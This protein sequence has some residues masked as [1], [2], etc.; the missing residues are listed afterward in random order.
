MTQVVKSELTRYDELEK[1]YT[2]KPSIEYLLDGVTPEQIRTI[3]ERAPNQITTYISD[4]I[5]QSITV[6]IP[7][8]KAMKLTKKGSRFEIETRKKTYSV[9]EPK[10]L[11]DYAQDIPASILDRIH[12]FETAEVVK[13]SG[14]LKDF[15]LDYYVADVIDDPDPILFVQVGGM[16]ELTLFIGAWE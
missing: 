10:E 16:K 3:A 15:T 5:C 7:K 13:K 4:K 6:G 9:R 8:V 1:A 14:L 12:G 11:K 2:L